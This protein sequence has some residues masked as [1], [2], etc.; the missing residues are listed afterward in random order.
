MYLAFQHQFDFVNSEK[1]VM[2]GWIYSIGNFDMKRP[3]NQDI[4][5]HKYEGGGLNASL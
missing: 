4:H 3:R 2:D 5:E 1:T